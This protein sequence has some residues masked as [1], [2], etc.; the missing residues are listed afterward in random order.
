MLG[1]SQH[2]KLMGVLSE[3][4]KKFEDIAAKF[5]D[6]FNKWECIRMSWLI[7]Y[8]LLHNVSSSSV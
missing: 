3:A 6:A 5:R 4:N 2:T 8:L 1:N 7:Q